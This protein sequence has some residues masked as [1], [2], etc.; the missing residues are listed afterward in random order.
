MQD[1]RD[2][3]GFLP[4]YEQDYHLAITVVCTM[5]RAG[6]I[7]HAKSRGMQIKRLYD[8]QMISCQIV[9]Y[10]IKGVIAGVIY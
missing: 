10:P 9:I 4:V 3:F 7:L 6:T 2:R 8:M 1:Q 5:I